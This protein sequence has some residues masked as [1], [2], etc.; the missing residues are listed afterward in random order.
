MSQST[1]DYISLYER[2]VALQVMPDEDRKTLLEHLHEEVKA[3][4]EVLGNIAVSEMQKILQDVPFEKKDDYLK[5]AGTILTFSAL[6]GYTLYLLTQNINPLE[7][8]L[9]DRKQT[10]GLGAKWIEQFQ[11]DQNASYRDKIDPIISL[12]LGKIQ[13]LRINQLLALYPE[14]VDL[15]YKIIEKLHQY[16]GWAAFQGFV[17]GEMENTQKGVL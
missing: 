16:I 1:A 10:S 13:E 8:D 4:L 15:P 12:F 5:T 9:K 17:L 3:G 11:K 2:W 7:E 6:G 14:V